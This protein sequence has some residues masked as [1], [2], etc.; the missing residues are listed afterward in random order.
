[1]ESKKIEENVL[2][3]LTPIVENLGFELVEVKYEQT[4]NGMTLTLFIHK[5]EG[6]SLA[7]CELVAKAIDE[8]LDI[9]NPTKDAPYNLNVSSL[10]L[11]RP[12]KTLKDFLR[13]IGR[14]LEISIN[15]P[16]G[17]KTLTGILKSVEDNTLIINEKGKFVTVDFK[18]VIKTLPIIKF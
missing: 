9:L 8:S 18:D 2:Q 7:D 10:G 11:D 14:N 17:E 4:E 5:T 3:H 12:I 6:I 16:K 1:M 13:S 15:T